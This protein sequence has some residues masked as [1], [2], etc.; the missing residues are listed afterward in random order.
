[1]SAKIYYAYKFNGS[2]HEL[3][4]ELRKLENKFYENEIF[5]TLQKYWNEEL[6]A[7][8]CLE[9][10]IYFH[11]DDI[12]IQLFNACYGVLDRFSKLLLESGKFTDFHYQ[13]QVDSENSEEEDAHREKVWEEIM[14]DYSIPAK[15]G[16]SYTLIDRYSL[17]ER[18][19]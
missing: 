4:P 11:K 2:I 18:F 14:S 12:Y 13:D 9:V 5:E 6:A 16:F 7:D 10:V 19:G 15:A 8:F 1:M 3:I 17:Y